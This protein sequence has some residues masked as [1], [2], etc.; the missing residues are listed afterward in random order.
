MEPAMRWE[1]FRREK[2]PGESEAVESEN[3]RRGKFQEER[4][5]EF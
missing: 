4:L 2:S 5:L 1:A 3:W